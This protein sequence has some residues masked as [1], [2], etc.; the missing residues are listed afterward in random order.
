MSTSAGAI[1]LHF[2]KPIEITING[3]KYEGKDV[4]VP[5]YAIASEVARI[6]REAYGKD[7]LI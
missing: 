2:I 1:I 3:V 7:I 6:A 4:E 5:N